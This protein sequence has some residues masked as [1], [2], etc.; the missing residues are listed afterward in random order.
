MKLV[1]NCKGGI[2]I[3]QCIVF[4]ALFILAGVVV[5]AARIMMAEKKVQGA[6]NAAVRSS[7]AAYDKDLMGGYGL[8]GVNT[9]SEIT[10]EGKTL[11]D[12][13]RKYLQANLKRTG[14]YHF[15]EY[16]IDF[17]NTHLNS[18]GNMV[19]DQPDS[20]RNQIMK[21]MKYKGP[22]TMTDGLIE[23]LKASG[24]F[25]KAEFSAKEKKTRSS[26]NGLKRNIEEVNS[27]IDKI[28]EQLQKATSQKGRV[29]IDSLKNIRNKL[30][31]VE[32]SAEAVAA[33]Y[34]RHSQAKEEADSFAAQANREEALQQEGVG[35]QTGEREFSGA[36]QE[37]RE[38]RDKAKQLDDQLK[39]L[40]YKIE[41]LQ[42]LV[43]DLEEEIKELENENRSI[44]A[45]IAAMSAAKDYEGIPYLVEVRSKNREKIRKLQTERN[46]LQNQIN[47]IRKS[48][49][50]P[51][52]HRM[53]LQQAGTN[54]AE[55]PQGNMDLSKLD[56]LLS[57]LGDYL[58]NKNIDPEWLIAPEEFQQVNQEE[59][60]A[61]ESMLSESLRNKRVLK[62]D[63]DGDRAETENDGILKF[64]ATLYN[65]VISFFSEG[66][67][68]AVEK[69][70]IVEYV[71][72]KFTYHTS[73]TE[74][75]HYF[76]KGEV[77]YILWGGTN[78][79]GNIAKT[80]ASI[81]FLR[82]TINTVDYFATSKVPHP[83][84][85]L[86]YAVGRGVIQSAV[87]TY[88]LYAGKEIPLCP[89]LKG[90]PISFGMNYSDHIRLFLLLQSVRNEKGQLHQIRQLIQVNMKQA[91]ERAEFRLSEYETALGA[92]TTVKI[93]LLFLPLLHLD[94]WGIRGFHGGHYVIIKESYSGF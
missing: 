3:F 79:N 15:V 68:A 33:E 8:F 91:E 32:Q 2:T 82:L 37:S 54:E 86:V 18:S 72:D 19:A 59:K 22:V 20:L 78:Q 50:L 49:V 11:E 40:I 25:Q 21:Y 80:M 51:N 93:N 42:D 48:A 55:K 85:R 1:S 74:R 69:M 77:E 63:G 44:D 27:G 88:D 81:G 71:M 29:Y 35:I 66:S 57:E 4:T 10:P 76:E 43:D 70:Y 31:Q 56:D 34:A 24:I 38:V 64:I 9:E 47:T 26:R 6:L 52:M 89:S 83:V 45:S 65:E 12:N 41:P 90:K 17:A 73:Q 92:R 28:N 23:K 61:Y 58:N 46:Q 16:N 67:Q 84:L 36:Q 39:N 7:L 94:A 62:N 5:D 60:D 53:T 30:A 14:P 75:D 13:F 87:D